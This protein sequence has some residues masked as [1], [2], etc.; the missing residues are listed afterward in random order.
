MKD[1]IVSQAGFFKR[2]SELTQIESTFNK[3]GKYDHEEVAIAL[4]DLGCRQDDLWR[5]TERSVDWSKE[6]ANGLYQGF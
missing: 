6:A 5:L 4:T 2:S 3:M 1:I